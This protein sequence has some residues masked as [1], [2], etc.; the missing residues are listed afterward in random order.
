MAIR[1]RNARIKSSTLKGH[2]LLLVLIISL[3]IALLC[4][5]LILV[6]YYY[7]TVNFQSKQLSILSNNLDSGLAVL[8]SK[9]TPVGLNESK[10][11]RLFD[12]GRDTVL[13]SRKQWG[14]FEV[15]SSLASIDD[16]HAKKSALLGYEPSNKFQHALYMIDN[17]SP[18][19][20]T[21]NTK[22]KGLCY[23]P[24]AGV[25]RAY[26][27]GNSYTGSKLVYGVTKK[28]NNRLPEAAIPTDLASLLSE[29]AMIRTSFDNLDS[30]TIQ[31]SFS[32]QSL[33]LAGDRITLSGGS[34]VGNIVIK[35]QKEL[36]ISSGTI[37][38]NVILIAPYIEIHNGFKGEAQ[39]YASDS[40]YIEDNCQLNY[41]SCIGL[42]K[43]ANNQERAWIE[44]GKN[45]FVS[46][47]I[48]SY[49]HH[50][51]RTRTALKVNSDATIEGYVYSNG[52]VDLKGTIK[53]SL[54]CMT[55]FYQSASGIHENVLSNAIVDYSALRQ[56]HVSA[57]ILGIE[58]KRKLITWLP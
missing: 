54:T 40:I 9:Q 15:V 44:I 23:I 19:R 28:S 5:S 2:T 16:K 25:E 48:F 21:G 11:L 20:L 27:G 18:L 46:G 50:F 29:D 3:I 7:K 6:T 36:I 8:L 17:N 10:T 1:T 43:T 32:D 55:I 42:I 26:I 34:Y 12:Q 24:K 22:L 56:P 53:G 31:Q 38:K 51:D 49:Q 45:A 41:P 57:S 58:S 4:S 39:I 14:V 33:L 30:N 13:L 37:L 52:K 47:T 35:A